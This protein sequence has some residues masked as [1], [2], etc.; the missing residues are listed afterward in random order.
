MRRRPTLVRTVIGTTALATAIAGATFGITG[1]ASAGQA[2]RARPPRARHP[3]SQ[4]ARARQPRARQPGP[5]GHRQ[6]RWH[7]CRAAGTNSTYVVLFAQGT[8]GAAAVS[9]AKAAGGTVV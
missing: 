8:D 2:A 3:P 5:G 4:A 7:R 6:G 9:A 1:Q